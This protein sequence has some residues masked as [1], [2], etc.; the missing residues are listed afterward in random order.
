MNPGRNAPCP[1]GSGKKYKQCCG[2]PESGLPVQSRPQKTPIAAPGSRAQDAPPADEISRLVAL[3]N[4]CRHAELENRSRLL[5]ER[6]P[7]SGLG[8]K[9]LSASLLMQGKDALLALQ[10]ATKFL[11]GEAELHNNLG[12]ALWKQSRGSE[13]EASFRRALQ[14]KPDYADAH[15][16]LSRT[17]LEQGRLDEA[18]AS[19]RRAL[20]IKPDFV[21]ALNNLGI[22]LMGQGR[23]AD[24]AASFRQILA[25]NPDFAG[26]YNSLGVLQSKQ[27]KLD[28]AITSYC[29]ALLLNPDYADAHGNLGVAYISQGNPGK[30]LACFQQQVRLNP[31]N[32]A[33]RHH[34]AS[35]T[36][37]N[38]E[39]APIQYVESL[40]DDY[41]DKFDTHL[42]QALKYEAP[43]KLVSFVT[44]HLASP[45][46]KWSILDLGCGTGL[47]GSAIA[48][49]A[50]QMV[51]VD[52]SKRM[53]KKAH[54]R[55]LYQRL[56]CS[57]LLTMMRGE[58]ASSYDA[59]FAADVFIYLGKLDEIIG[60]IKRLLCP[61]GVFAFS[62]ETLEELSNE[63]NSQGIKQGYQLKNTGRY[64]H[65][66][67][68]ITGLAAA[69]GFLTKEMVAA[70]IRLDHGKP[71]NGYLVLWKN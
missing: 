53:L 48:P 40:F 12:D 2:K 64:A 18:E 61:G 20:K 13:A 33:A 30:A 47:V 19:L 49:F 57:D 21:D 16:N 3:Y 70:Q 28:E 36:G 6:H 17:L 54:A 35:L 55:N 34:I 31:G 22:V 23:F 66:V 44:Q 50:R 43:Q 37:N 60:E 8:W 71:V 46:E 27:G 51:G 45:A 59:I 39:R 41:A 63:E 52:L 9:L 58:L 67:S 29:K 38:T 15:Y 56:E 10:N 62:I 32:D 26:A 5:V 65:S 11:P 25:I 68:Y 69:N 1:C 7:D 24:A 42:Q 4:A 14:I